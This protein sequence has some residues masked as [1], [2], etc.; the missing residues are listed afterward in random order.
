MK[1]TL[2]T[3]IFAA[4]GF[5]SVIAW[6]PNKSA[7]ARSPASETTPAATATLPVSAVVASRFVTDP[8][9]TAARYRIREQLV[10]VDLPNDAIGETKEVTGVIS[11][12]AKG[13]LI[14]AESKFTIGIATL[15][16]D[17]QRRDGFVRGR[18]LEADKYPTVTLVPTSIK[19]VSM[20]LPKSGSKAFEIIGDL[21]VRGVTHPTTWKVNA[22]FQPN[23]MTGK[24]TTAFTF[25][26][27]AI[28]QP[29]VPVV[30]SVADTIKL[31]LD[32]S[33]IPDPSL[34]K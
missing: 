19:G 8:A 18:V 21:T 9:G 23:R 12:D 22:Q 11:A 13:N 15:A 16:S 27:F 25:A 31:E 17:K 28:D 24:A 33:L 30:L 34:K 29:R 3:I 1:K 14:P 6:E 5:G 26:D 10:G 4:I 20:P 32:F 2:N 7:E